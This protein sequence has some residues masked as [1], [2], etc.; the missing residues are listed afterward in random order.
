[1]GTAGIDSTK[2]LEYEDQFNAIM[3][4]FKKLGF[5]SQKKECKCTARPQWSDTWGCPWLN[6]Q[7]LKLCGKPALGFQPIGHYGLLSSG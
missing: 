4:A 6:E 2:Y 3:K 7:K 5:W 1:M